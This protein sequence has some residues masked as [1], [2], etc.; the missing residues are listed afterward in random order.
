MNESDL[1]KIFDDISPQLTPDVLHSF[2]KI[3]CHYEERLTSEKNLPPPELRYN[4][5]GRPFAG[6]FLE[7][8]Q[9]TFERLESALKQLGF[10]FS[11][12]DK[13][14]EF[15]CGCGRLARWLVPNLN[16][17]KFYGVDIDVKAIEWCKKSLF[18]EFTLNKITPPL[19]FVDNNF[20]LIYSYS[21]FTHLDEK[22]QFA[23]LQELKRVAKKDGIILITVR[24]K[25]DHEKINL[26]DSDKAELEKR[27]FLFKK[28][29]RWNCG[30]S[31]QTTFHTKKYVL[32]NYSK[33]F[34]ILSYIENIH[35]R[36]GQDI[37]IL[38]K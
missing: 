17:S 36:F 13:I 33:Y 5:T 9:I 16:K 3:L 19:E 26:N 32:D 28:S 14:L 20:G 8:G 7:S 31:Y 30:E 4:V 22:I 34:E 21:V 37:V 15:G 24:G 18:G 12:F 2:V 1:V 23:W 29:N 38:K 35:K 10:E 25:D 11:S 6:F 27:G